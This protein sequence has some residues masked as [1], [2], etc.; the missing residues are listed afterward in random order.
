VQKLVGLFIFIFFRSKQE[1]TV[2]LPGYEP[3]V[4]QVHTQAS[5]ENDTTHLLNK[6]SWEVALAPIKQVPMNLFIMYMAGNSISIFPIMMVGM[7]IVR[8]IKAMFS[9]KS[10]FKV[11]EGGYAIQQKIIYIFGNLVVL[12]LA[13]YKCHSMGLLPSHSSDWLAFVDPPSRKEYSGGG[14]IYT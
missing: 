14:I 6:R 2:D 9:V 13:L 3:S 8:P 12:A 1:R 10:A 11:L 7:L 4:G 5:R